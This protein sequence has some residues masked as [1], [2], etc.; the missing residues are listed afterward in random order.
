MIGMESVIL[1]LFIGCAAGGTATLFVPARTPGDALQTAVVGMLGGVFG[2][3]ALDA[4]GVGPN[5]T[6]LGSLGVAA[7][8]ALALLSLMRSVDRAT[9]I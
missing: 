4:R 6:R 8:A 9:R 7:A 1:W 5:L 3:W 2:G